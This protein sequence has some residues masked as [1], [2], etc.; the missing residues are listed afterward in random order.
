LGWEGGGNSGGLVVL[1]VEKVLVVL[2]FQIW[3]SRCI[4]VIIK[5]RKVKIA[6]TLGR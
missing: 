3:D 6:C 5:A 4:V 1:V 2:R